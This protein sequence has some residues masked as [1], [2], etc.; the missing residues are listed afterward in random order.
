MTVPSDKKSIK[1]KLLE[2]LKRFLFG[3]VALFFLLLCALGFAP[4][5]LFVVNKIVESIRN[6]TGVSISA[7]HVS[8][9]LNGNI[10]LSD[11]LLLLIGRNEY[12]KARPSSN[13]RKSAWSETFPGNA[14]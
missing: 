3:F 8:I 12:R 1:G 10:Y 13:P 2:I 14:R 7:K 11:V 9:S 5:Q 4:V 6:Q